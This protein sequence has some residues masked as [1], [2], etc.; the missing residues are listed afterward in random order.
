MIEYALLKADQTA[1]FEEMTFP[2]FKAALRNA[3]PDGPIIAIGAYRG[4]LPV[5]LILAKL[6]TMNIEGA[7]YQFAEV[8]S[9]WVGPDFR[10]Q[11]IASELW[12]R[13]EAL[14][15]ARK[16]ISARTVYT[17]GKPSTE[18]FERI[19]KKHGWADPIASITFFRTD[20]TIE[21]LPWLDFELDLPETISIFPWGELT[22]AEADQLRARLAANPDLA[23][24]SPFEEADKID[25][26]TSLG[27]RWQEGVGGWLITHW[28]DAQ[29][30]RY[31]SLYVDE[32]LR[33]MSGT[34]IRLMTDAIRLHL[35]RGHP[36]QALFCVRRDNPTMLKMMKKYVAP[37]C[38]SIYESRISFKPFH[39]PDNLG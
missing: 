2:S 23:P 25:L 17:T 31:T 5:G 19:L 29:T 13:L 15:D 30:I 34:A 26:G 4:W 6:M 36:P 28:I 39:K 27:A 21:G 18:A 1:A 12:T 9:I 35:K 32:G 16:L 14:I 11:G 24:L 37:Y 22:E 3:S 7:D 8:L 10:Q 33:G 20:T 38:T